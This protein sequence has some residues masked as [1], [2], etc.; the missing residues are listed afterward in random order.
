MHPTHARTPRSVSTRELTLAS[1]PSFLSFNILQDIELQQIGVFEVPCPRLET[2]SLIL[3]NAET[4]TSILV[5]NYVSNLGGEGSTR[6]QHV[7][8]QTE[9]KAFTRTCTH[10]H[11]HVHMHTHTPAGAQKNLTNLNSGI[12][13]GIPTQTNLITL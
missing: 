9:L 4:P 6:N 2:A 12:G 13:N 3:K 8:W 5:L 7:V 1:H 10:M 11:M